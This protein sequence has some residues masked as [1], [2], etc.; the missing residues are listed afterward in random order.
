MVALRFTNHAKSLL[1]ERNIDPLWVEQV[2]NKPDWTVQDAN[3]Q[4]LVRAFGAVRPA[5][6]R[7]LRVVYRDTGATQFVITAFFDRNAAQ[8]E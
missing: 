6:G 5:G 3:D 1:A 8:P 7:I 2:V 4:A